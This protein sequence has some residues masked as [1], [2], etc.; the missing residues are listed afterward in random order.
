[1]TVPEPPSTDLERIRAFHQRSKHSFE[2]YAAGPGQMDWATQPDP[3]RRFQGASVVELP[4]VADPQPALF[5]DLYRPGSIPPQPC[6]L[7]NLACL[8]ELSLGLAAWKGY[9]GDRWALRCNPSSGNL[10]PTEGYIV[11]SGVSGLNDGIYHYASL[12]HALERRS[13]AVLPFQ[14]LLVGFSSIH[15]REAWK[16][17]ERAFRYCQH[18]VGHALAAVRY[19]AGV[20][21]WTAEVLDEWGDADIARLLGLDRDSDFG[22]AERE[23]PDLLCRV[24]PATSSRPDMD[25]MLKA[26]EQADWQGQANVLSSRHL[27]HWPAIDVAHLSTVKPRTPPVLMEPATRADLPDTP[28][29]TIASNLIRQR[30]SAQAFDGVTSITQETFFR[31]LDATLPRAGLPPFD[32]WPWQP[33]VHLLLFVHRVDDFAPGLYLLPR[34]EGAMED[35]KAVARTDLEWLPVETTPSHL[36]LIRLA[37][38]NCQRMAATLSCQQSIAGD[39]AFSLGMLAEFDVALGDGSWHY[40]RLFRECGMIGQVL[41]LE[42]EAAG[43]RGTGIGCFF[44]DPVHEVLGLTGTSYQSLY[45][46]TVGGPVNDTRLETLPPYEHLHRSP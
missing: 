25:A 7:A 10:H 41:Y 44:D 46:F 28:S 6:N 15:W 39:S 19:A 8:L 36:Q 31:L 12:D 21:G 45:H 33:Q 42:A 29:P 43:I 37:R 1:V 34:R 17:G 4:L 23:V 26:L 20:L 22:T 11:A 27:H 14:G 5:R 2:R 13:G 38:G 18:D 35:I 9:A 32:A 30:R 40:R 24:I 16:Y 3:F